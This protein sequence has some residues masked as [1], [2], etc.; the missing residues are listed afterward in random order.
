MTTGFPHQIVYVCVAILL[1]KNC[2]GSPKTIDPLM[3]CQTTPLPCVPLSP[4]ASVTHECQAD[5]N[6]TAGA[7]CCYIGCTRT[8]VV[9]EP[10]DRVVCKSGYS[11]QSKE[12]PCGKP[13][14]QREASCIP[15]AQV[16]CPSPACTT[17][18]CPAGYERVNDT[19]GCET[20]QCQ[21]KKVCGPTC[22]MYC[23]YG[24]VIGA[25]G[26]PICQCNQE[27]E[28][29]CSK[30][31]CSKTQEC[32]L[33]K[34]SCSQAPCKPTA[35][36]V[37]KTKSYY[38]NTCGL[39]DRTTVGYPVLLFDK[40][41]EYN[42]Y[43]QPCPDGTVCTSLGSGTYRCCWQH[44]QARISEAPRVGE[45]PEEFMIDPSEPTPRCEIDAECPN[46]QKC[47]YHLRM[48]GMARFYGTCYTTVQQI[49]ANAP[50][51][52]Q[53]NPILYYVFNYLGLC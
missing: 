28:H 19:T 49:L 31:T 4:G 8:C 1:C 53:R 44:T 17:T 42:C 14:C 50:F 40:V 24:N 13:P 12:T 18:N 6:C 34:T 32:R 2:C 20:C 15:E 5:V 36:C 46:Q 26:C 39:K 30:M 22:Q 43:L 33:L 7:R 29:P 11:C 23:A 27:P 52:C 35:V 9:P 51:Y 25:D 48:P 10:C 3:T 47:C 45:C 21:P 37:T 16:R 41:T 38:D